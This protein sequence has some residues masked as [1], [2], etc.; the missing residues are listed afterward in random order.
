MARKELN[1][2]SALESVSDEVFQEEVSRICEGT[3]SDDLDVALALE[4]QDDEDGD[5]DLEDDED[6]KS[7]ELVTDKDIEEIDEKGCEKC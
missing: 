3:E 7:I 1:I 6:F 5:I 2:N 4:T